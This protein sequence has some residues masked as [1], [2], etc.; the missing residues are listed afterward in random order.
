MIEASTQALEEA[1]QAGDTLSAA[2]ICSGLY[3][4]EE[5][6]KVYG[7]KYATA[8]RAFA[9]I[10]SV[11]KALVKVKTTVAVLQIEN[12]KNLDEVNREINTLSK[13][14]ERSITEVCGEH[15]PSKDRSKYSYDLDLDAKYVDKNIVKPV[16]KFVDELLKKRDC[17]SVSIQ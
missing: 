11:D 8:V 14:L 13:E 12:S 9:I 16:L 1:E 5:E 4:L 6:I 2:F 15:E 3:A 17:D 7:E 10:D